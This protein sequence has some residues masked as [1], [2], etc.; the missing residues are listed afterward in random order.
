MGSGFPAVSEVRVAVSKISDT[1]TA[2]ATRGRGM[3][4]PRKYLVGTEEAAMAY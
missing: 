1:D 4:L 3:G 2:G